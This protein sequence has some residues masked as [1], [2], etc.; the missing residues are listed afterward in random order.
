M[1]AIRTSLRFRYGGGGSG[2][3]EVFGLMGD[4]FCVGVQVEVTVEWFGG[5]RDFVIITCERRF[6]TS[7]N[8]EIC[9]DFHTL[10]W[11]LVDSVASELIIAF[12]YE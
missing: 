4:M 1:H 12:L 2:C 8:S 5:R 6:C 9:F 11:C 3:G 7:D 10:P